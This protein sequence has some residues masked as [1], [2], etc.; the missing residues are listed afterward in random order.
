MRTVGSLGY[1]MGREG[2]PSCCGCPASVGFGQNF[3]GIGADPYGEDG[4]TL[5]GVGAGPKGKSRE[6][7][8]APGVKGCDGAYCLCGLLSGVKGWE[9]AYYLGALPSG[10]E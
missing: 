8:D 5:G 9:G 3:G 6:E 7:D 1:T 10:R 2:G 4:R